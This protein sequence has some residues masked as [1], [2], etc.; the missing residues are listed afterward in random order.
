MQFPEHQNRV[1]NMEF[2][3]IQ[4]N[5]LLSKGISADEVHRQ[6]GCF[7]AGMQYCALDRPATVG[8]GIM[9]FRDEELKR[10][11]EYFTRNIGSHRVMKFVPASGAATRMFKEQFEFVEKENNSSLT[12][13]D[14]SKGM[15]Q[16]AGEIDRMPFYDVLLQKGERSGLGHT[17]TISISGLKSLTE[18][19]LS[20]SGMNYGALPKALIIFHNYVHSVRLAFEE[21]LVEGAS[22]IPDRN[23]PLLL[24][25]TLS[26]NHVALFRK[27]LDE[28]LHIYAG[29]F[30]C[31]YDISLS[32]QHESTDTVAATEGNTPFLNSDGTLLFR[33]GGH[34][35]LL[36]NLNQ[37]DADIVFI[38]NIDN[39]CIEEIEM[40]NLVWK[41]ALGGLLLR[42][43][44]KAGEFL[45]SIDSGASDGELQEA[46][47]WIRETF[48]P[49]FGKGATPSPEQIRAF[50]HRPIR[51]CGMVKNT[52]EPG[53]GPF[54]VKSKTGTSLQII[55][56]AQ[57][58][59]DDT[60]QQSIA[61]AATH[62]N[63]VDLVCSLT[64]YK[65][66]KFDLNQFSDP[67]TAFI[68]IKSH[69]GKLLKAL[70][71]PGL[72]NGAMANWLT[73][74]VEV[75]LITFNPVKTV[76]DLL[77]PEHQHIKIS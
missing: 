62:F 52:G 37:L 48:D 73:L 23:E 61:R 28:K 71:H 7:A 66:K 54:W 4:K 27:A 34:G 32:V 59:P 1:F 16:F 75:P 65:G 3:D 26:P 24:H 40:E 56:S 12:F 19:L 21:H 20:E 15:Q 53:G 8:D 42:M 31:R 55:E 67:D 69:Q 35:A 41:R 30:G 43:R 74:F 72:W 33:P 5:Q 60:Q 2:T 68:S 38:K 58:S 47:E 70:E 18:L 57:I 17:G 10:S 46:V 25:F 13:A 29:R 76:N 49:T 45:T 6:L 50:L 51:V 14:L 63:P 39:V 44:E 77:R 36:Y 22:L 64:D 9:V 11:A